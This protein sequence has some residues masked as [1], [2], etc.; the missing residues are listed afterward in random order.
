MYSKLKCSLKSEYGHDIDDIN[1]LMEEIPHKLKIELSL[2]LYDQK[3]KTIRFFQGKTQ[4][5]AS[6]IYPLIKP[7]YATE[8]E[9]IYNEGD[10]VMGMYFLKEGSCGFVLPKHRNI[11]YINIDV[12]QHFG[13]IDI[14]GSMFL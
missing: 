3:Y 7:F 10:E 6:W 2:H 1:E 9:F 5:F 8:D 13:I 11:K 4:A 12:G 14:V